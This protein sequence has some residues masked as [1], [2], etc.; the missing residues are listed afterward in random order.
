M[1]TVKNIIDSS[2][3][4]NL[5]NSINKRT[6]IKIYEHYRDTVAARD[7]EKLK[8]AHLSGDQAVSLLGSDEDIFTEFVLLKLQK[9]ENAI[10][11]QQY[12][13]GEEPEQENDNETVLGYSK[14]FLLLYLIEYF[15]LKTNPSELGPYLK[16]IRVGNAKKYERE[17]KEI[18]S[19]I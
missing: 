14:G 8:M 18:Y 7:Q 13:L 12:P 16:A 11:D 2:N 9:F 4:Q 19:K 17:L 10:I 6:K 15:L 5:L 3:Y 1:E